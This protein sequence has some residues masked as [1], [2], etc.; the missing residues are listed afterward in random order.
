M[1]V[2][3]HVT[4][5][6]AANQTR[7]G[8]VSRIDA[9]GR[10]R[11]DTVRRNSRGRIVHE[12]CWFYVHE[13][14]LLTVVTTM[15]PKLR[16]QVVAVLRWVARRPCVEDNCGTVCKCEPCMARLALDDLGEAENG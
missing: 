16:M 15:T 3:D 7:R 11:V 1:T 9:D 14:H 10:I 4:W 5:L 8:K 12:D 13:V 2:G 6:T